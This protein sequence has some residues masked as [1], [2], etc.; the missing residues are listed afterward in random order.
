MPRDNDKDNHSGGRRDRPSGG[1]GR[2]GVA[3]GP[4]KKF[5]KRGFAGKSDG[6]KRDGER[7]L[8]AG[9]SD[10]AKS[11]WQETP[12]GRRQA[13][14]RQARPRRRSSAA[15]GFRRSRRVRNASTAMIV[16][17]AIGL[18]A[19]NDGIFARAMIGMA[20]S[21]RSRRAAIARTLIATTARRAAIATMGGRRRALAKRNS[22]TSGPTRLGRIVA[23]SGRTH[24][25]AKV[26]GKMVIVRAEIGQNG[27]SAATGNSPRAARPGIATATLVTVDPARILATAPSAAI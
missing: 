17:A 9:K 22:A 8:F 6:D 12:C 5:A 16:P 18:S 13:L 11:V 10:G 3:R 4:E 21:A 19:V 14:C 24:R 15:P 2:S 20:R 26:F 23:R 27:N 25:A 7:R 1:K